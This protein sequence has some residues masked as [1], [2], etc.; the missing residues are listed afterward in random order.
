[1]S[2][3]GRIGGMLESCGKN[4]AK[5]ELEAKY[6]QQIGKI[7][8]NGNKVYQKKVKNGTITTGLTWDNKVIAEVRH[9]GDNIEGTTKKIRYNRDGDIIEVSRSRRATNYRNSVSENLETGEVKSKVLSYG[10]TDNHPQ[11]QVKTTVIDSDG[12]VK[13]TTKDVKINGK[14]YATENV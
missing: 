4:I 5:R 12:K 6:G 8:N 3:S 7:A 13:T 1:M 14:N 10:V 9:Q 2:I 11:H